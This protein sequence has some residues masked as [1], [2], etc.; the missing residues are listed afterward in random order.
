MNGLSRMMGN[1]HVRFLGGGT[2]VTPSCYPTKSVL[3]AGWGML[4]SMLT[5]K[6]DRA[7]SHLIVIG[8][9]FPS[10]KTCG[11]CG[12]VNADLTLS[13]RDWTCPCGIKHDRDL[14]AAH[15]IDR[16]GFRLF[17]QLVAAG[18]AETQNAC[19]DVVSPS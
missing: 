14:N 15:N 18:C 12:L 17:E 1:Y 9:F 7:D 11:A 8:R 5:Y 13:D 10:S 4:R 3:D 16:E 6:A 19:G 2:A